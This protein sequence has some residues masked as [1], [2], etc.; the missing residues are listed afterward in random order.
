M[1]RVITGLVTQS[2]KLLWLVK[3]HQYN[4]F[5]VMGLTQILYKNHQNTDLNTSNYFKE[6]N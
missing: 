1:V 4:L 3:P 5:T 2:I 6:L